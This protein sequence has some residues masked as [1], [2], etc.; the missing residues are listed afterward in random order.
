M[1]LGVCENLIS[2]LVEQGERVARRPRRT[3]QI[4]DADRH[5]QF[6]REPSEMLNEVF[7]TRHGQ[8]SPSITIRRINRI[9]ATAADA[10]QFGEEGD[11]RSSSG[12]F[13][14]KGLPYG[15]SRRGLF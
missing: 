4:R 8:R 7:I 5:S 3:F 2:L 10:P 1:D 9:E 12:G 6:G 15:G 14:A 11:M 13:P